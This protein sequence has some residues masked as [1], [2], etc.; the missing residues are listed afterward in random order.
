M[1]LTYAEIE[2][3]NLFTKRTLP[4]KALVLQHINYETCIMIV[5]TFQKG[6]HGHAPD[7]IAT[8]RRGAPVG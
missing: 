3:E 8:H 1:G 2:V 5:Q 7:R 6:G 4:I